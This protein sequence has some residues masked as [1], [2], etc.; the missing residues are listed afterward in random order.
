MATPLPI[1]NREVKHL[2]AEN[3]ECEDRKLPI[4]FCVKIKK[5]V[6]MIAYFPVSLIYY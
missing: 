2:N 3:S 6:N 5:I 4:F 1:P